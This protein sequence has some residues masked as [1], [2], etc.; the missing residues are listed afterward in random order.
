MYLVCIWNVS[1]VYLECIIWLF[2]T[3]LFFQSK[4]TLGAYR[5]D[6]MALCIKNIV[7]CISR[8]GRDGSETMAGTPAP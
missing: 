1:G 2:K 4:W 6:E 5:R 8:D 7:C 3:I